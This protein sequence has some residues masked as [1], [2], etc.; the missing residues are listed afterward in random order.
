MYIQRDGCYRTA[1]T[2]RR[3]QDKT[4]NALSTELRATM[5]GT[6]SVE[7]LRNSAS[8]PALRQLPNSWLRVRQNRLTTPRSQKRVKIKIRTGSGALNT[9]PR[10]APLSLPVCSVVGCSR[11]SSKGLESLVS[12]SAAVLSL[13]RSS[14]PADRSA[15]FLPSIA[16]V[17]FCP[18]TP[19][20]AL[21]AEALAAW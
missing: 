21:S 6:A 8:F 3:R 11:L 20:V 13:S 1:A 7:Q 15:S 18:G 16:F 17:L 9:L 19:P 5:T 12:V 14:A 2:N 10:L 4:G